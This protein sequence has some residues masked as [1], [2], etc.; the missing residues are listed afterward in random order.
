MSQ[1]LSDSE[2]APVVYKAMRAQQASVAGDISS[3]A[4]EAA[5]VEGA[6]RHFGCLD[7]STAAPVGRASQH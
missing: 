5:L 7:N 3:P 4:T 2:A 1:R 6:E